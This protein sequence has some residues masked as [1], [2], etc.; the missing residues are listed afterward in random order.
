LER[1]GRPSSHTSAKRFRTTRYTNDQ[2]TQ[3]SHDRRRR[4]EPTEPHAPERPGRVCE[5]YGVGG[6]PARSTHPARTVLPPRAHA[7]MIAVAESALGIG[8]PSGDLT[9]H[10]HLSVVPGSPRG[11]HLGWEIRARALLL[12][13]LLAGIQPA[14]RWR[15]VDGRLAGAYGERVA[16]ARCTGCRRALAPTSS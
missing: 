3:S 5:P 9:L 2:S 13:F 15:R 12:L 4:A 6:R 8:W 10:P 16:T 11:L 1:R 14:A 7:S